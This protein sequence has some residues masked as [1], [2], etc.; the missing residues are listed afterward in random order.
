MSAW[1]H[2]QK[3]RDSKR[4]LPRDFIEA[5]TEGFLEQKGD[6]L[7]QEDS[8]VIGGM[9]FFRGRPVTLLGISRG[10]DIEE[11]I[12]RNFGSPNPE[13]YRKA[14]RLA[15]Q[16]EKFK[17][18]ILV[19]IDTKG[20]GCAR[21]AEERGQGEAIARC[22]YEISSLKVPFI[23]F[24]TGEGGSGGALALAVGDR[25]YMLEN[26]TYSILS[27]EGFSSILYK[28]PGHARAAAEI[29]K[30]TARDML[31]LQV[32]EGIVEE[33]GDIN[34]HFDQ[35]MEDIDNLLR[36][37]LEETDKLPVETLLENRYRR[38]RKYGTGAMS[39]EE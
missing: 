8:A 30:I 37:F 35:V 9:A 20:A 27:P 36:S 1:D 2:V 18:P 22:L 5:L 32:I 10:K 38:F 6:R 31:E 33:H 3:A 19:F 24:I 4:P 26:S 15:R 7:Y 39:D 29:M 21:G 16:A 11:N 12:R 25:V 23:T 17:R 34:L 14:L 28:A 13:G